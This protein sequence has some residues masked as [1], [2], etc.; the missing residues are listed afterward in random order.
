MPFAKCS[1]HKSNMKLLYVL[2]QS[3]CNTQ[4]HPSEL[5]SLLGLFVY[6]LYSVSVPR[7]RHI[8]K[9]HRR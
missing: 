8:V 3:S 7:N 4:V 5:Y 1:I 9:I 6:Y 2:E